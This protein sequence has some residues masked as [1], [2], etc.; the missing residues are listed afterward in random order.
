M[1]PDLTEN[2]ILPNP[3]CKQSNKEL[4]KTLAQLQTEKRNMRFVLSKFSHEFAAK[5]RRPPQDQIDYA[6]VQDTFTKYG[7]VRETIAMIQ[8]YLELHPDTDKQP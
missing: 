4:T 8:K 2:D 5:Y 6:P 1:Y 3:Y 7:R